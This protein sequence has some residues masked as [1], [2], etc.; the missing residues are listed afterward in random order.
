MLRIWPRL[1]ESYSGSGGCLAITIHSAY[2]SGLRRLHSDF[3][4]VFYSR[5]GRIMDGIE[6]ANAFASISV[7][8]ELMSLNTSN[9]CA[10]K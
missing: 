5:I 2:P 7:P 6:V 4:C 3:I 10:I 1:N 9:H 8:W